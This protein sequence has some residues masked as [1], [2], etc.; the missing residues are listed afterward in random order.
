MPSPPLIVTY[1]PAKIPRLEVAACIM[2]IATAE[3][4][5]PR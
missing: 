4:Q 3:V 5:H 1:D 2:S